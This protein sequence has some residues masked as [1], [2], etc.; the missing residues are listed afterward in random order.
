MIDPT[1]EGHPA[2]KAEE[3]PVRCEV[4]DTGRRLIPEVGIY[5][6][7]RMLSFGPKGQALAIYRAMDWDRFQKP[8]AESPPGRPFRKEPQMCWASTIR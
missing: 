4:S 5:P 3:K 1:D 7:N 2:P 8:S 6:S